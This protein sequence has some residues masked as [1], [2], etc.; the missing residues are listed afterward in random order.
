VLCTLY[1]LAPVQLFTN[2]KSSVDF[3]NKLE[4]NPGFEVVNAWFILSAYY[5]NLDLLLS[6]GMFVFA[7][8]TLFPWVYVFI[9]RKPR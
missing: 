4:A 9:E 5:P 2:G 3:A 1:D 7:Y 8:L 6:V